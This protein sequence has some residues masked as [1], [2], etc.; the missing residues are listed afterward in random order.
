MLVLETDQTLESTGERKG[1][2]GKIFHDLFV[3]SITHPYS[4]ASNLK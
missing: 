2:F 3:C 4:S 1:S